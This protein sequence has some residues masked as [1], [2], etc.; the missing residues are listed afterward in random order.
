MMGHQK[1]Q[2]LS[3]T[4]L[5]LEGFSN[6]QSLFLADSGYF[7][8]PLGLLLHNVEGVVAE[9]ADDPGGR[10]GTDSADGP[11]GQVAFDLLGPVGHLTLQK[12]RPE[13]GAVGGMILPAARHHK[14]FSGHTQRNRSNHGD[15]FARF[16]LEPHH[17][18]PIR[19]ILIQHRRNGAPDDRWFIARHVVPSTLSLHPYS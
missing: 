7:R 13:L 2:Q 6:L 17:G 4:E 18:V 1:L 5:L 3:H 16:R 12:L 15:A 11:G 8:Q 14:L 9:A 10:P 19:F